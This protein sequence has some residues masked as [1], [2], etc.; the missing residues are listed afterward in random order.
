MNNIKTG[1]FHAHPSLGSA[2][3]L[4]QRMNWSFTSEKPWI[5]VTATFNI[6]TLNKYNSLHRVQ[7]RQGFKYH[8][9]LAQC[10]PYL[11]VNVGQTSIIPRQQ[12]ACNTAYLNKLMIFP[13]NV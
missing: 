6:S 3:T 1:Y 12:I 8:K 5:P 4:C 7:S 9:S 13:I 11:T 2:T 10:L